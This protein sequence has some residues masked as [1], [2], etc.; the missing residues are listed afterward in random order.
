VGIIRDTTGQKRAEENQAQSLEEL[1]QK[2]KELERFK[3]I[4]I[5]R[6]K[7]IIELKKKVKELEKKLN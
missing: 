5:G 7:R 6:E 2:I 1:N 3:N 4:T